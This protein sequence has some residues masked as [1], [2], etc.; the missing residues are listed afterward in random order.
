MT[1]KRLMTVGVVMVVVALVVAVAAVVGRRLL[2]DDADA[3]RLASAMTQAPAD[4]QRFSWTDWSAVRRALGVELD[5][6]SPAGEVADLLDRGF[7]S[8]LTS[9]SALGSSAVAMHDALGFSPAT[10]DWELYSQ[11]PTS[12]SLLMRLSSG[13]DPDD[14]RDALTRSGYDAPAEADD[15]WASDPTTDAITGQVTPELTF[16]GFDDATG[17][18]VA[19]DTYAGARAARSALRDGEGAPVTP[20]VVTGLGD[21]VSAALYNAAEVCGSLAM[22]RADVSDQQTADSLIA[23]A[24]KVNPLTGFA[25]GAEPDGD[26][27][28]VMSFENERQARTNADTR[29]VLASGPA[30]GQGGDF[31]ERFTLGDV[32]ADGDTVTMAL[33]P[34]EGSYV[35]S[36]LSTGPLLFATC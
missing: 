22:S 35:L 20:T 21:P 7:E 19:S 29:A 18:L 2:R 23:Q 31:G 25:M 32:T 15:F 30:P 5:A 4:A 24:G 34:V 16:I 17:L 11:G 28:V 14:V 6:D 12:A 36:D 3:G 1:R 9:T 26:V 13:V 33:Q 8:D 10:L 27:R